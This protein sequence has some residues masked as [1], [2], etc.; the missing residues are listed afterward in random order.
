MKFKTKCI[1]LGVSLLLVFF[2]LPLV[3]VNLAESH[4][5]MGV[6]TLLFFVV[7]PVATAT[8]HA[9]I[10]KDSKRLW[11]MPLLVVVVFLLSYWIVLGEIIWDLLFYAGI[12]FVIGVQALLVSSFVAK[13]RKARQSE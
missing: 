7:N 1:V 4:E 5:F 2:V 11:W 13:R 6:M 10:G 9:C 3:L 12:Y 8:I